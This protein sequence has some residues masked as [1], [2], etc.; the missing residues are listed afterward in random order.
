MFTQAVDHSEQYKQEK[1]RL[2]V[3]FGFA[4]GLVYTIV[5]W[6]VDGL[7]L[8]RANVIFP[9]AK[10]AIGILPTLIIC[11]LAGWVSA[12]LENALFS[13]LVWLATGV[14]LCIFSCHIPFEG[15]T[16]F[17]RWF[18]PELT[19]RATLP[20]N[21][22]VS[23]RFAIV[24]IIC[25]AISFIG[26]VFYKLLLD[27]SHNASSWLGSLFPL[28]IWLIIFVCIASPVDYMMQRSLRA[29]VIA[30]NDLVPKKINSLTM[31]VT[32][33]D[34]RSLAAMSGIED[35]I[36]APRQLILSRYDD[37]LMMMHVAINFSGNWVDCSVFSNSNS[38]PPVPQPIFCRK[39]D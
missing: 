10:L 18:N 13:A 2:G 33:E 1:V 30:V 29:S 22:G 38:E 25:A 16:Q 7:A 5:L 6:G 15:V 37:D 39:I 35:I 20:F 24:L 8:A 23:S 12:K 19:R 31:P 11:T 27:N 36:K 4:A 26:G 14:L 3:L 32:T 28:A 17:Y 9:W 34:T 21:S